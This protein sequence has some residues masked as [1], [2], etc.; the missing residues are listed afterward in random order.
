MRRNC[1]KNQRSITSLSISTGEAWASL[2][3]RRHCYNSKGGIISQGGPVAVPLVKTNLLFSATKNRL[4]VLGCPNLGYLND[5]A[6]YYVSG[7]MAMCQPQKFNASGSCTG[8][9]CCQSTIPSGVDYYQPNLLDMPKNKGDPIDRLSLACE[10]STDR[11]LPLR[12]AY[13]IHAQAQFTGF[14]PKAFCT[15]DHCRACVHPRRDKRFR[16]AEIFLLADRPLFM[17]IF[18]VEVSKKKHEFYACNKC[19]YKWLS[20]YII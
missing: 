9:A 14:K 8:V 13:H 5:V 4:V 10:R 16:G 3:V 18:P 2:N 17:F 15:C 7:C 11:L 20:E 1:R 12:T 6:G 19:S